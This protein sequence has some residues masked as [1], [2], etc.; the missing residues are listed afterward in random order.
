[1]AKRHE[2]F[3]P[4]LRAAEVHSDGHDAGGRS[5][6]GLPETLVEDSVFL[7]PQFG[8]LFVK[9]GR[10][11]SRTRHEPPWLVVSCGWQLPTVDGQAQALSER[12]RHGGDPPEQAVSVVHDTQ[13]PLSA[14]I[15]IHDGVVGPSAA[16]PTHA[17]TDAPPWLARILG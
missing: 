13:F 12:F 17:S 1:M 9:K 6:R 5:I 10:L 16:L 14:E 15:S 7:S 8:T 2:Q 4:V 11:D 3:D